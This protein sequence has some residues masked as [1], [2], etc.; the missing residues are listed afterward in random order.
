MIT[1]TD[2]K[3]YLVSLR[4]YSLESHIGDFLASEISSIIEIIGTEKF[5]TVVMDSAAN[6]RVARKKI[7]EKYPHISN[8][9][10]A[11]HTINLIASDLVKIEKIKN[12]IINCGKITKYFNKSHQNLALLR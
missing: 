4:N 7:Q 2:R 3:E 5:A 12:F 10:C 9:R 8:I 11:T 6:C 1:T